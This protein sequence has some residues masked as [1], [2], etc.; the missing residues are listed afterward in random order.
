[1]A[2]LTTMQVGSRVR[3]VC[4]LGSEQA[5]HIY[6]SCCP[7]VNP[8]PLSQVSPGKPDSKRGPIPHLGG[9]IVLSMLSISPIR[10]YQMVFQTCYNCSILSEVYAVSPFLPSL[11][12]ML[13]AKS[14][15][16]PPLLGSH[17]C[18][19]HVLEQ[20]LHR[21]GDNHHSWPQI[22]SF[23][24]CHFFSYCGWGLD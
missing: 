6:F 17:P 11:P 2:L 23:T 24:R 7:F 19:Y 13:N 3:W 1:M 12:A 22:L 5:W 18:F 15:F 20:I 9:P 10:A 8:L 14:P 4:V 16:F 21:F